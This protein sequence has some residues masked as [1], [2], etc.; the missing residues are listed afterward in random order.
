M[1]IPDKYAQVAQRPIR[2]IAPLLALL[3]APLTYAQ[4]TVA[5][6]AL[7]FTAQQGGPA[8]GPQTINVSGANG[9]TITFVL[10]LGFTSFMTASVGGFVLQSDGE[11]GLTTTPAVITVGVIWPPTP[12]D[13]LGYYGAIEIFQFDTS[14]GVTTTPGVVVP[15]SLSITPAVSPPPSITAGGVVPVDSTV[16]TIQPGEWVS[17]Y[18]TNLAS[19]TVRWNGNF[20][21]SLGGASVTINGR[22][23][24]L[25]LVSPTQINLQAPDDPTTGSVP[26]VVT[27]ASVQA[28]S[29]VTLAEF[30]PSF[31][32][33]DSTH[34]AGIIPRSNGSGA[35]GG[36]TYDILGPTG[37]SPG[38]PTVAAKAGDVVELFGTGFGPTNPS[39]PAG[40]AFSG[41]APTTNSVELFINNTSIPPSFSGLA[42]AGLDQINVTIPSGLGTGDVSLKAAVG[43][44]QTPAGVVI[45]L[46]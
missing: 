30:A 11:S 38:H 16:P 18:G 24:Y 21:T 35:Y 25:S 19:S 9:T 14:T 45:S 29:T 17:I 37:N 10:S 33:L 7:T 27:T 42:G 22:P 2:F 41:A 44:V 46:Q 31:L 32:L 8:P 26:V 15:V 6:S 40:Q 23:A 3:G 43:G 20:P 36:G 39:V 4:L 28:T 1:E 34:V 5:P 13:L 12:A